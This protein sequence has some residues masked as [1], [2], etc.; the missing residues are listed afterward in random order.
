MGFERECGK[1]NQ[2]NQL[3]ELKVR[4]KLTSMFVTFQRL[5][6]IFNHSVVKA[7]GKKGTSAFNVLHY[8][9]MDTLD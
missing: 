8:R 6:A 4:G 3:L 1:L 9:G 5:Y 2:L 7:G